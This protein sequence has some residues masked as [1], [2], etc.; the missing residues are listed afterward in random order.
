MTHTTFQVSKTNLSTAIK[1]LEDAAKLYDALAAMPLQRAASRAHMIRQLTRK[2][3]D[4]LS[5]SQRDASY[6][7][8]LKIT[9][10]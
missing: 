6:N 2:L 9:K 5:A 10:Q 4:K 1:Y 3:K 7:I 8:T